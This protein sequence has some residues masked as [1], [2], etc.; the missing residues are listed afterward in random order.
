MVS[1]TKRGGA[2]KTVS[3][4]L[5]ILD[6]ENLTSARNFYGKNTDSSSGKNVCVEDM[7][8]SEEV[9]NKICL[10]KSSIIHFRADKNHHIFF[11]FYKV[12]ISC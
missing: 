10:M 12:Y 9:E 1:G 4:I 11:D 3:C 8:N 5:E 2:G 6:T 7:M